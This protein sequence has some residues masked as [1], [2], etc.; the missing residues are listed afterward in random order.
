[1]IRILEIAAC[2]YTLLGLINLVGLEEILVMIA[3][4]GISSLAGIVAVN[5]RKELKS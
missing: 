4:C 3:V 2:G 1:M 5:I